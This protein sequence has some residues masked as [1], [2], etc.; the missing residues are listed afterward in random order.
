MQRSKKTSYRLGA[1]L[2]LKE[3]NGYE[4]YA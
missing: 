4:A 3:R 2:Y 1:W